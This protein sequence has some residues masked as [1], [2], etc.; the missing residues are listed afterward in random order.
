MIHVSETIEKTIEKLADFIIAMAKNRITSQGIF[1]LVLAGGSSPKKLY[2]LLA[3]ENY[4][5][6]LDWTKVFFF[7]GDERYVPKDDIDSNYRMVEETFFQP[8]GIS[9]KNIFPFNTELSPEDS[10]KN[11]FSIVKNFFYPL[12]SE[13]DLVLLGL[14][15]NAHTASLF[16]FTPILK[17]KEPGVREVYLPDSKTFRLSMNAPLLNLSRHIV[18][19]VY[20]T[21]KAEAVRQVLQPAKNSTEIDNYQIYPAQ[22]IKPKQGTIDWFLDKDAASSIKI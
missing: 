2:H 15:D 14:G 18:F 16:P 20:G 19:L 22:L 1:S 17:E 8:L 3:S 10:A 4:K 5:D 12:E 7:F 6:Q 13:F 11:Y 21:I 9:K